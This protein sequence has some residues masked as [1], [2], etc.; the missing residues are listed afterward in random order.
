MDFIIFSDPKLSSSSIIQCIGRGTRPDK[1]GPNGT[2]LNKDCHILIPTFIENTTNK[3]YK[4]IEILKYI[5]LNFDI[6]FS[7][8]S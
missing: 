6:Q 2:N 3:Y 1:L 7:E 4:I 8:K 5:I